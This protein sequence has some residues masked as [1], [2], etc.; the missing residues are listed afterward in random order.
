MHWCNSFI[1]VDVN[2]IGELPLSKGKG[3]TYKYYEKFKII[4]CHHNKL[5]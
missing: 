2:K 3:A 4:C 5:L 1:V